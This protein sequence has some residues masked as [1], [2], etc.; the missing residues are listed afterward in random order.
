MDPIQKKIQ[1]FLWF[2]L[3]LFLYCVFCFFFLLLL[4]NATVELENNDAADDNVF[5]D[6]LMRL[7]CMGFCQRTLRRRQRFPL[8]TWFF[9][10]FI[11][12]LIVVVI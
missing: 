9:L 7:S 8:G 2:A 6:V 4:I 3:L 1:L 5:V 11:I 12:Y 10:F